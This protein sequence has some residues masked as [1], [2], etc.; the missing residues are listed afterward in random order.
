M[1][2]NQLI[3]ESCIFLNQDIQTFEEV[4][5]MVGEQFVAKGIAKESYVQAVIDREKIYPTGLPADG[6]NIAIPHTDSN[7]IL[8]PSIGVVVTKN[9][10]EVS[11][12][13]NP[14]MKLSCQMFFPLAMEHPKKQLALL[15]QLMKFFQNKE[16]LE[17]ICAATN[18]KE[19]LQVLNKITL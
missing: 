13:G 14:E 2:D 19:V 3:E 18:K 7:H 12:M 10:I 1:V 16:D 6:Y 11:M 4:I 8:R 15:K 5:Q 17:K 9:P